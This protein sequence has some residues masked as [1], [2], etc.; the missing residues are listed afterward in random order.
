MLQR[1][2]FF[3]KETNICKIFL[4]DKKAPGQCETLLICPGENKTNYY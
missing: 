4:Q 3:R 1:Y 2:S